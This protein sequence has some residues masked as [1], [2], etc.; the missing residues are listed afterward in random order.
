MNT[1][2]GK[3]SNS[4][5]SNSSNSDGIGTLYHDFS[6]LGFPTKQMA[7]IYQANQTVKAPVITYYILRALSTLRRRRMESISFAELFCADGFYAMFA[8][9]FG[10]TRAVGYD[11]DRDGYL[12][13]ADKVKTA[14]GL[15]DVEFVKTEIAAIPRE[16]RFSIVANVGGLYHVENP[17]EILDQSYEMADHF[18]IVQTVV[19]LAN[20]DPDYFESPA[21]G[22]PWGNRFSRS[23]FDRLI[24]AR[25]WNVCDHTSNILTGNDRPEDRGSVYYLIAKSL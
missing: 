16:T 18:L 19:S 24:S 20:D 17:V 2:N 11:N 4:T 22:W 21:P 7:G 14:L 5:P 8:R 3:I 13:S 9:H 25:E 6:V 23:S 1:E 10:A 15:G 12:A